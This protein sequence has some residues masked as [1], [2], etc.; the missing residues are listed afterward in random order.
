[1]VGLTR[2]LAWTY[3]P[4]GIRVNA[5]CPGAVETNIIGEGGLASMDQAGLELLLPVMALS[6][7]SAKPE[8]VANLALF[9]VSDAAHYVSG[10]IIPV[11]LGWTAA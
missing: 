2:N 3:R 1:M 5:I 11:D 4:D 7:P 8:S 9:L 6:S 10:A